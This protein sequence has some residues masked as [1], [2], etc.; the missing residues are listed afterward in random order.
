MHSLPVFV[1]PFTGLEGNSNTSFPS[2]NSFVLEQ[3][4]GILGRK[5]LCEPRGCGLGAR[6]W[7][8]CAL[9]DGDVVSPCAF[10]LGYF[11]LL[12]P[13]Q[14]ADG[15]CYNPAKA[16][17]RNKQINEARPSA[18]DVCCLLGKSPCGELARPPFWRDS[19]PSHVLAEG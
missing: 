10:N 17:A 15:V 4:S 5:V 13:T 8:A 16:H 6:G 14:E 2:P 1:V 19:P 18:V 7:G 12:E 11:S 9:L 3:L